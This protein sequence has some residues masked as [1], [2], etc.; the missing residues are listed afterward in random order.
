MR[1]PVLSSPAGD[2]D[3]GKDCVERY[4][5]LGLDISVSS[6]F[7]DNGRVFYTADTAIGYVKASARKFMA[8]I[9]N[10]DG[11]NYVAVV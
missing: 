4:T 9:Q 11:T 2:S 7:L 6:G 1:R 8:D 5:V 3:G 10:A